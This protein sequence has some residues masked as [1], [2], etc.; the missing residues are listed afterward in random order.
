MGGFPMP[1]TSP[2]ARLANLWDEAKAANMP[3]KNIE[4]NIGRARS[5]LTDMTLS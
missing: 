1:E 4:A 5:L 3:A 2:A